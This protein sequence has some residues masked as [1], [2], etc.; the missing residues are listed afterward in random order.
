MFGAK[1]IQIQ[2]HVVLHRSLCVVCER[3]VYGWDDVQEEQRSVIGSAISQA[4]QQC[5]FGDRAVMDSGGKSDSF[6]TDVLLATV[7]NGPVAPLSGRFLI[8]MAE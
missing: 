1:Q 8:Q 3:V 6:T 4:F 7:K 5:L 2:C